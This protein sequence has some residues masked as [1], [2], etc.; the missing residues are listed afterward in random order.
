MPPGPLMSGFP[1]ADGRELL[2]IGPLGTCLEP[3]GIPCG[4]VG[5]PVCCRR[6]FTG[7]APCRLRCTACILA[8]ISCDTFK[9]LPRLDIVGAWGLTFLAALSVPRGVEEAVILDVGADAET[10]RNAGRGAPR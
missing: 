6:L 1:D 8:R 9:P 2:A 10:E 7:G 3:A 5:V 4:P